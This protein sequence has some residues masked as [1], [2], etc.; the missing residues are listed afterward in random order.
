MNSPPESYLP[1]E[2]EPVLIN[3]VS[4]TDVEENALY[5]IL[6]HK[7]ELIQNLQQTIKALSKTVAHFN[8]DIDGTNHRLN[9][10][11]S[12]I[13]TNKDINYIM[14]KQKIL[15]DK[16]DLLIRHNQTVCDRL[17]RSTVNVN[18]LKKLYFGLNK[19]YITNFNR[20]SQEVTNNDII[21]TKIQL[22]E[23][24]IE[25]L[26]N[27]FKCQVCF[28]KTIDV[29]LI[30]CN[31][32]YLCKDCVGQIIAVTDDNDSVNCPVCNNRVIEFQSIYLPI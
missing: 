8:N 20:T 30:P 22:L 28:T 2:S 25:H 10:I 18:N 6:Q 27:T 11:Q 13:S 5:D 12:T 9:I 31:H 15:S 17:I 3:T 24:R 14:A 29:I 21:D 1:N 23:T 4:I 32:I 26:S 19:L 7:N 16:N